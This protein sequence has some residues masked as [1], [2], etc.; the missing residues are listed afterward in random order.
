MRYKP[1][2]VLTTSLTVR[3]FSLAGVKTLHLPYEVIYHML[4]ETQ[5]D[6]SGFI[7]DDPHRLHRDRRTLASCSLVCLAWRLPAQA[8][9]FEGL[10]VSL[11]S[12]LDGFLVFLRST[13][14]AAN[15]IRS[16]RL[17][18]GTMPYDD[19]DG[20]TV[21]AEIHGVQ[22]WEHVQQTSS[23]RLLSPA[24]LMDIVG[25][26]HGLTHLHVEHSVFLGWPGGHSLPT[27]PKS[28]QSLNLF[29]NAYMPLVQP[30]SQPFD[31]L[32][33]FKLGQLTVAGNHDVYGAQQ[34]VPP[35]EVLA[36]LDNRPPVVSDLKFY[37]H[38][39]FLECNLRHGGCDVDRLTL[40]VSD[41]APDVLDV[42]SLLEH[43]GRNATHIHLDIDYSVEREFPEEDGECS[44]A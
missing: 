28:L 29:G 18:P 34:H 22:L 27:R 20:D 26:L 5:R 33:F 11:G 32:S 12:T 31:I 23:E 3:L 17:Q 16:L 41:I 14:H 21:D 36:I 39:C 1:F 9:L 7:D 44:N 13:P 37:G 8:L 10:T 25:T 40:Y 15:A 43:Y 35:V 42:R 2:T 6:T 24:L 19:G 30:G 4:R 38:D